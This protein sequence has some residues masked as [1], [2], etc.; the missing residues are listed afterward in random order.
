MNNTYDNLTRYDH[1]NNEF[2]EWVN[3]DKK[4]C[5]ESSSGV[6][7]SLLNS[8]KT[9]ITIN[10]VITNYNIKTLLD[11]PCG[12]L[13]WIFNCGFKNIKYTGMDIS[14]ELINYNK[15]K[16][17]N[18]DFKVCDIVTESINNKYDLILCRDLL[19]HLSYKS[20]LMQL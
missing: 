8:Q 11:I 19:H 14:D 18:Y 3:S 20:N 16:Y 13:N 12:D 2:K 6:G 10:N 5:R 4:T 9:I 7:S 17:N 1:W 15:I